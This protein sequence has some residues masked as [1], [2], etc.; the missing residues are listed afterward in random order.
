MPWKSESNT[1]MHVVLLKGVNEYHVLLAGVLRPRC[2]WSK[3]S[4]TACYRYR[5]FRPK[6]A[7]HTDGAIDGI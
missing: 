6:V 4:L 3:P 5:S 7:K 2:H 1:M